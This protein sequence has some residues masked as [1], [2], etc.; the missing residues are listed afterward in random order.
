MLVAI[1]CYLSDC[2]LTP[3]SKSVWS[4]HSSKSDHC[5]SSVCRSLLLL[6]M[7]STAASLECVA[8]R[9][10]AVLHLTAPFD[11]RPSAPL[12]L[13]LPTDPHPLAH[14]RR[15]RHQGD[16]PHREWTG[17]ARHLLAGY[18]RGQ[19][20]LLVTNKHTQQR[21][22][23]ERGRQPPTAA[24]TVISD[25]LCA[26]CSLRCA[27]LRMHWRRQGEACGCRVGA[28]AC[29][30]TAPVRTRARPATDTRH[31]AGWSGCAVLFTSLQQGVM[32]EG[33]D[34][35]TEQAL[36]NLSAVVE[37]GG[38]TMDNVLKVLIRAASAPLAMTSA[39]GLQA[40]SRARQQGVRASADHDSVGWRAVCNCALRL[41]AD[42]R[43]PVDHG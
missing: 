11:V 35:Q 23:S 20:A 37:A 39:A 24:A 19:H 4:G 6:S 25:L 13:S 2:L 18:A 10:L 9:C 3:G 26:F 14:V 36:K 21:G 42:D 7:S 41:L 22:H 15:H 30:Q 12:P 40:A 27:Q 16:H 1:V 34:G 43:V 17:A 29:A 38:S 5:S 31:C 33:I 8:V 28:C 32:A